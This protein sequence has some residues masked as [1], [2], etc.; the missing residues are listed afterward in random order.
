MHVA[1]T[2]AA[3]QVGRVVVD[4]FEDREQTLFTHTEHEDFD[5]E[6]LDGTDREAFGAALSGVDT[7]VHLAWVTADSGGW[8]E[9]DEAN[10]RMTANALAAASENDLDRVVLASSGHVFGMYNRDDP[11]KFE[12]IVERPTTVVDTDTS[13]RPDSFYGVTKVATEAFCSYYAD[14]DDIDIVVVRIGWL[15]TPEE[16]R[17]LQSEPDGRVRFARAMWLSHR[18]C[19]QLFRRAAEA[20]VDDSP[21]FAHG[22]SR[23]GER[24][25][26]LT[27]TM[28][29]LGYRPR[30]DASEELDDAGPQ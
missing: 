28:Q 17:D 13:P 3:G 20:P 29:R 22:I 12:S 2:G 9:G 30:D 7:L 21:L 25:L 5:S 15:M 16:L 4:A 26:S 14:R 8:S 27:G 19:Q 18:D 6:L 10:L 1:I 23:N 24:Y 11:S